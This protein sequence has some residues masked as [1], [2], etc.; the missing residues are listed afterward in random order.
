MLAEGTN[1]GASISIEM[2]FLNNIIIVIRAVNSP[3]QHKSLT[4][5]DNPV[6]IIYLSYTF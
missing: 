1:T 6:I 3:C 2:I 5:K 4:V